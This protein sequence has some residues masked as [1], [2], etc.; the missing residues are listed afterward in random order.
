MGGGA[1]GSW[2]GG[3]LLARRNSGVRC[4]AWLLAGSELLAQIPEARL[5]VQRFS[6]VLITSSQFLS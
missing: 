4:Q 6:P 1:R 5:E 3:G 2:Q